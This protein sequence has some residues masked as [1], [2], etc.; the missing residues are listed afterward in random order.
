MPEFPEIA[1]TQKAPAPR[2]ARR[3]AYLLLGIAV[4][5][6]AACQ[7]A[8]QSNVVGYLLSKQ[9]GTLANPN[10]AQ[11]PGA[12]EGRVLGPGAQPIAGATVLVAE[13][14]GTPHTARTNAAGHYRQQR[15]GY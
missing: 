9:M 5:V 4:L 8:P 2:A 6:M 12:L 1:A 13:R 14:T 11:P 15:R 10:Q 7:P 3:L